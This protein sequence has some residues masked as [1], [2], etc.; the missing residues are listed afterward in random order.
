MQQ[1]SDLN[2][3]LDLS[4]VFAVNQYD[5][6]LL[7][8][9]YLKAKGVIPNDWQLAQPA[10][11]TRRQIDLLFKNGIRIV[12]QPGAIRFVES[13]VGK[14]PDALTIPNLARQFATTVPNLRYRSVGINP[15]RYGAFPDPSSSGWQFIHQTLLAPK[16]WQSYG[17]A[18][19]QTSLDVGFTLDNCLLRV[20]IQE[21]R[22]QVAEV[23][24]ISAVLFMGN[25][26]YAVRQG[27]S[28]EQVTSVH[29]ALDGLA[30]NLADFQD[31]VDHHF[32]GHAA[33]LVAA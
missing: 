21:A 19:V 10:E 29:Q 9:R 25:Y 12:G 24:Q 1:L 16:A 14:S 33:E 18:P 15:R 27:S 13:M 3:L 20:N 5:P 30:A 17:K 2:G 26:H 8:D 22:L 7:T 4:I 11:T 6:Q 23:E 31:L 28:E 32:L